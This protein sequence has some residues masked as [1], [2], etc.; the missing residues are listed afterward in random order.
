MTKAPRFIAAAF[1]SALCLN[2]A[3]NSE[4]E[5]PPATFEPSSGIWNYE[6]EAV[7]SND[8]GDV[9]GAIG[10]PDTYNLD[11]DGGDTF[12][13]EL[14]A[15]DLMCEIDGSEFSCTP[16]TV[17]PEAVPPFDAIVT[18][19]VTWSGEFTSETIANGQSTADITCSGSDCTVESC[20]RVVTFT[21][22]FTG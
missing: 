18:Y 21:A 1:V 12:Q 22:E 5:D 19:T 3:C 11:Y 2:L 15:D 10:Q 9:L 14:Q 4:P 13:V 6:E 20:T 17:G 8:C 16:L 7:V